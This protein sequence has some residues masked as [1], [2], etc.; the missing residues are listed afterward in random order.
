MAENYNNN[1]DQNTYGQGVDAQG[2]NPQY[3]QGGY[4]Q[5]GQG[6][7]DPNQAYNQQYQGVNQGYGQQN[8]QNPPPY[9][10]PP[11]QYT[12]PN[13][14]PSFGFAVLGFFF[15]IV[16]L[17]LFLVWKDQ[18]PLKAKSAGKGALVAVIVGAAISILVIIFSV[19]L[20]GLFFDGLTSYYY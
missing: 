9:Y 14:A 2:T 3:Q 16:G 8:Y 7:Y 4:A 18:S 6:Y 15:P 13:D 11:P 10:G 12:D 1:P 17:I 19:V 20:A 5:Q